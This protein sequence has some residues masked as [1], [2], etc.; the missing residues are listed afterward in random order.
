MPD[1]SWSCKLIIGR[2]LL[3]PLDSTIPKNELE[4]MCAGSNLSWIV[5]KALS[6]WVDSSIIVGDSIIALCWVMAEHKRLSMFH[7]NRVIQIRRLTELDSLYR[8]R[9]DQNPSAIGTRPDKVSLD[10]VGPDIGPYS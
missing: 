10:D 3:A 5:K 4:S 1:G 6:E 8:V 2:G 7:R 9:T